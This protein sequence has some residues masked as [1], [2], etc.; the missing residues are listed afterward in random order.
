MLFKCQTRVS[1]K[2]KG[3]IFGEIFLKPFE[4]DKKGK[5][6]QIVLLLV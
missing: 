6:K 3:K 5:A 2:I 1:I 4:T